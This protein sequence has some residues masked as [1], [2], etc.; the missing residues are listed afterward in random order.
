MKYT[1]HF[2]ENNPGG[3]YRLNQSDYDA[4][5][6]NGWS[7]DGAR[8][9]RSSFYEPP[10]EASIVIEVEP[11]EELPWTNDPEDVALDKAITAWEAITHENHLDDGCSCCGRPY[12][13]WAEEAKEESDGD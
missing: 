10:A 1:V 7:V 6:R 9:Q 11:G 4:L 5:V 3:H 8:H 2:S 12:N 13:F